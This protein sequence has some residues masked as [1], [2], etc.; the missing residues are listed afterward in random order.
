M[1]AGKWT[2]CGMEAMIYGTRCGPA[3]LLKLNVQQ[4]GF[5]DFV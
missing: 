4:N 1:Y 2:F 3:H 5:V